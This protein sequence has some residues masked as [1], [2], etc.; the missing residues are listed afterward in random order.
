MKAKKR[1]YHHGDLRRALLDATI[2]ILREGGVGSFSLR[3]VARRAGVSPAA[4]YHHFPTKTDLLSAIALEGFAELTRVMS[5]A[6]DAERDGPPTAKLRA[7]GEA[8][9][10]FAI[11][12]PAHFQMMFRPPTPP[13]DHAMGGPPA[14]SFSILLDAVTAVIGAPGVGARVSHPA[15]VVLSWSIVHG[16]AALVLDGPLA[17]GIPA[18]GVTPS[19]IPALVTATLE[20]L[21]VAPSPTSPAKGTR[22]KKT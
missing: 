10:R 7:I 14:D 3:D 15:L 13:P 18:L 16:A 9:V 5:E 4:P 17:N 8:Y 1:A 12:H 19:E 2:A 21:L 6:R 20:S 11:E 22:A